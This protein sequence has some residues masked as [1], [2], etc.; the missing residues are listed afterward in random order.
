MILS[1]GGRW[2]ETMSVQMRYGYMRAVMRIIAV[3]LVAFL[4]LVASASAKQPKPVVL[5]PRFHAVATGITAAF[6]DRRYVL[7]VAGEGTAQSSTLLDK[8]TGTRTMV[9]YP[10]CYVDAFNPPDPFGGPW[11]MFKCDLANQGQGGFELY[12]LTTGE[13]KSVALAPEIVSYRN[14]CGGGPYCGV[15]LAAFG[16]DWL[17]WK[18]SCR[19]C[20]DTYLFQNID[21]G[22]L[23][24]LPGWQVGGTTIPN[25]S[26]PRLANH[27]CS[28]LRVPQG[29]PPVGTNSALAPNPPLTFAGRFAAGT[30][31]YM[32]GGLWGLR[33][34]VERCGSRL[35]QVLTTQIGSSATP[36]FAINQHAVVW[37]NYRGGSIRGI[38]LPSLRKFT[39]ALPTYLRSG[40][41]AP[42]FLTS[43]TLYLETDLGTALSATAAPRPPMHHRRHASARLRAK[44]GA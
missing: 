28:P 19:E 27:L 1:P 13:W 41:Q 34:L 36:Q 6:T 31:W 38:F 33:L 10:G 29:F 43:H 42:L 8:R 30:E 25:L 9:S 14:E 35:H 40:P 5:H 4:G 15:S 44:P 23:Q 11:L 20:V 7:W 26:S 21:T 12:N 37:Q 24:T 16:A 22:Q 3:A 17:E 32:N 39:I 18:E 2:V